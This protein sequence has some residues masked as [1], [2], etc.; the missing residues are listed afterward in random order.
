VHTKG[1]NS[2]TVRVLLFKNNMNYLILPIALQN[3]DVLL[4]AE[5]VQC[6]LLYCQAFPAPVDTVFLS[7]VFC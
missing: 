1:S 5:I 7:L 3:T 2:N 6:P 4:G